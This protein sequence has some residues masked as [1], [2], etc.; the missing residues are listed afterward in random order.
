MPR[1]TERPWRCCACRA[2][3]GIE[4]GQHLH[5][6]YKTAEFIISGLVT[7]TCRRCGAPND[8]LCPRPPRDGS[9]ARPR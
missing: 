9:P 7:T 3:L 6:R 4:R 1:H 2:L 5:L 8:I